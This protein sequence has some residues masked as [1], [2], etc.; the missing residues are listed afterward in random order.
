MEQE[1]SQVDLAKKLRI[2]ETTISN[3][4]DKGRVHCSKYLEKLK[5]IILGLPSASA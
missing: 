2:N 1:I 4:G 3:Q 5:I